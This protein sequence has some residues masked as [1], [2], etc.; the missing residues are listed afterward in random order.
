MPFSGPGRPSAFA[1]APEKTKRGTP[2]PRPLPIARK[3]GRLS[4]HPPGV[5]GRLHLRIGP[6]RA[7]PTRTTCLR[8][9]SKGPQTCWVGLEV[10]SSQAGAL[11]GPHTLVTPMSLQHSR[12]PW[13]AALPV[14]SSEGSFAPVVPAGLPLGSCVC[15]I[16]G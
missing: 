15:F 3:G 2:P 9:R 14:D 1:F 12:P 10:R 5:A 4:H 8:P 16:Q 13:C 11:I 7:D 6:A